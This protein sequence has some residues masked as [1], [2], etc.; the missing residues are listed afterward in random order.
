M[1]IFTKALQRASYPYRAITKKTT[2]EDKQLFDQDVS[3]M[4]RNRPLD[5]LQDDIELLSNATNTQQGRQYLE[6]LN[7]LYGEMLGG[8]IQMPLR[9]YESVF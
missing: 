1:G 8:A 2:P 6:A 9:L 7:R 5:S 3:S 4:T